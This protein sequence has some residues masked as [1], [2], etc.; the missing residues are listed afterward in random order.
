M[1][2]TMAEKKT[3]TAN[4][5]D[6]LIGRQIKTYRAEQPQAW[7]AEQMQA[8][9]HK[10]SQSTVWAVENG[11]QP[12]KLTEG[13]DL[14][15]ILDVEITEIIEELDPDVRALMRVARGVREARRDAENAMREWMRRQQILKTGF[16]P[17]EN[18]PRS[19]YD[20]TALERAYDEVLI[21]PDDIRSYAEVEPD[22]VPSRGLD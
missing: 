17:M 5:R 3:R 22:K 11:Y 13:G 20:T 19:E 4:P 10:W 6:E 9:G 14:A 1:V 15:D 16:E 18:R 21:E 12:V 7:L 2:L 8:R